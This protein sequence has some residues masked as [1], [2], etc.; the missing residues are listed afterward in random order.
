VVGFTHD[1]PRLG[2]I[3]LADGRHRFEEIEAT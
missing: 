3:S 1:V 2:R